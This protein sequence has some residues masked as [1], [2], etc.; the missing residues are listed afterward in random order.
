MEVHDAVCSIVF[1]NT[2]R[3]DCPPTGRLGAYA[4]TAAR[5]VRLY[6]YEADALH[7]I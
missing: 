7:I 5:A 1:K 3:C 2:M 4:I 6:L